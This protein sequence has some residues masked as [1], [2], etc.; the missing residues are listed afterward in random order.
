ML[1]S[2]RWFREDRE[3]LSPISVGDRV[4]VL[5]AGLLH[6][7]KV[8]LED[9]GKYLCWVNNS[10]GEETVQV[11]LTVTGILYL[12]YF[13]RNKQGRTTRVLRFSW[14]LTEVSLEAVCFSGILVMNTRLQYGDITWKN[15]S[16][17]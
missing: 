2:D 4:S 6:I 1:L 10:A 12:I 5:A 17:G 11:T 9:M 8:R 7:S 13:L 16:V 15:M 3:Q 14:R